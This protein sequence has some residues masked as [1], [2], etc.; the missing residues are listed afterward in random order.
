MDTGY[1]IVREAARMG[2]VARLEMLGGKDMFSSG[3]VL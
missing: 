3:N 1:G 2:K